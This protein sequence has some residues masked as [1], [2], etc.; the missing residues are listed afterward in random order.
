MSLSDKKKNYGNKEIVETKDLR[1]EIKILR[2]DVSKIVKC[3]TDRER[4]LDA[5]TRNFGEEFE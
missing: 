4:V 1:A 5:I 3:Y 2:Y